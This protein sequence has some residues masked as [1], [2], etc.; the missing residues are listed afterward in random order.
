M[1]IKEMLKKVETY[2][3]VAEVLGNRKAVLN[4]V[5]SFGDSILVSTSTEVTDYKEFAKY[6]RDTYITD[7]A[8][9]ILNLEYEFEETRLVSWLDVMGYTQYVRVSFEIVEQ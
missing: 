3:E 6:I 4:F 1:K 7:V 5:D 2:N 8:K 9:I